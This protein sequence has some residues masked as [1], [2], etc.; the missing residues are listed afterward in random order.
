MA[1]VHTINLDTLEVLM[2][3]GTVLP[4]TD[5]FDD[6]GEECEADS[7]VSIVAGVQGVGFLSIDM[8]ELTPIT[9]H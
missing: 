8:G 2:D 9:V 5:M 3:D 6:D 1:N 7:A 4:I